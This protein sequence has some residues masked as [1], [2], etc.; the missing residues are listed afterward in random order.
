MIDISAHCFQKITHN[1]TSNGLTTYSWWVDR[2]GN[3][4]TY[5]HGAKSV[6]AKGCR[7]GDLGICDTGHGEEGSTICNCDA[8]DNVNI[9]RGTLRSRDQLPVMELAYGDSQYRYSWIHYT[10]GRFTCE[11]KRWIYPSEIY[12]NDFAVKVG[13]TYVGGS[14]DYL[15]AGYN[16]YFGETIYDNS[17]GSWKN[18]KF[19][20]PVDGYY[21]FNLK[22][23]F[24]TSSSN[25]VYYRIFLYK[26]TEN[27]TLLGKLSF[28]I[29]VI[30]DGCT[31]NIAAR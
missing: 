19:T 31:N 26:S 2:F 1:C 9:D 14:Y 17:L 23:H 21:S 29:I 18:D 24:Y 20:A 30:T 4:V 28:L 25:Y 8:R 5:W 10:L 13:L 6:T 15:T 11:G 7:C 12:D 3:N 27:G 22:L 16:I